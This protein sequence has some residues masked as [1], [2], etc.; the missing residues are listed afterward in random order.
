MLIS[1][2]SLINF[3]NTDYSESNWITY[4]NLVSTIV[5]F[6]VLVLPPYLFTLTIFGYEDLKNPNSD[7]A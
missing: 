3:I 7:R 2:S 6:L 1:V 5:L 4:N